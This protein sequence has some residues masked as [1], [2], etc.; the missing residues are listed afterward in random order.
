VIDEFTNKI[1]C[2]DNRQILKQIP[3][4]SVDLIFTSPPYN[5]ER[6]YDTYNDV[7]NIEKYLEFLY[8]VFTEFIRIVKSSGRI[9]INIMPMC[10]DEVPTHHK[11]TEFFI[12]NG[13]HW[14]NEIIWVKQSA[15]SATSWGSWQSP[16]SPY[17]RLDVEFLEIFYKDQ[18]KKEGKKENIDIN[19]H[20]FALWTNGIWNIQPESQMIKKY[21]HP[22]VFPEKLV[23]RV[24]KLFTY[25]HD[26]VLDPFNGV[27]TTSL[28]CH[29]LNRKYIGI[30]ISEEYCKTARSRINEYKA[31]QVDNSIWE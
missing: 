13:L 14:K 19:A 31:F 20:D 28:I 29:K 11:V 27:G 7:V 21:N 4:E 30:D 5:F 15:S 1:I 12:R 3:S 23:E 8:E 10:M 26:I 24:L 25:K 2:S 6:Q 22:A 17:I 16:S 9:I 18:W